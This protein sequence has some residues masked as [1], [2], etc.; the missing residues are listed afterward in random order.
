MKRIYVSHP[1][2]SDPDGNKAKVERICQDILSSG[3]GLPISPIHLFSFT[4]DTHREHILASCLRLLEIVDE[5]W[6]YGSSEGVELER[7]RAI[8]LGKPVRDVC[9]REAT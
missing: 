8:E 6:I 9:D 1:Y 2:A 4:D 5:V 3:E 7:A